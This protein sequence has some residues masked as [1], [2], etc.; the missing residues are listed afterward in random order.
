M[1]KDLDTKWSDLWIKKSSYKEQL[2]N[3]VN[4]L[5][6][7]IDKKFIKEKVKG[8]GYKCA[9]FEL[10]RIVEESDEY[11]T[12][13]LKSMTSK[14]SGIY[15]IVCSEIMKPQTT[16]CKKDFIGQVIKGC[17]ADNLNTPIEGPLKRLHENY[18]DVYTKVICS[19][20]PDAIA[21]RQSYSTIQSLPI[22][23][24]VLTG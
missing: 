11:E 22:N 15:I 8:A 20:N 12:E 4:A 5:L 16:L 18:L 14:I 1:V 2:L 21:S 13:L 10:S 17:Y 6:K 7:Q 19:L 24:L 3:L 23:D 9:F